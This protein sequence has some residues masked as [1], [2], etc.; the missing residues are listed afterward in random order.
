MK[1][2]IFE[3]DFARFLTSGKKRQWKEKTNRLEK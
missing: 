2:M 3:G 1:K